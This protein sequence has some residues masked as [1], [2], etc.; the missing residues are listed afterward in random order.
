MKNNSKF[1]S[2]L[3]AASKQ[4]T[5]YI[6]VIDF[7]A[8]PI[9]TLLT[10]IQNRVSKTQGSLRWPSKQQDLQVSQFKNFSMV[11]LNLFLVY[12]INNSTL[13]TPPSTAMAYG[14]GHVTDNS[15]A[16]VNKRKVRDVI[17]IA[18][19][20]SNFNIFF[21]CTIYI[22][23]V[24]KIPQLRYSQLEQLSGCRMLPGISIE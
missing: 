9:I 4:S 16:Y 13:K 23:S 17:T 14:G 8:T 10:R 19:G 6:H 21:N 12:I 11:Q 5:A 7:Y 18:A 20:E 1:N 24:F 15:P 3:T 22:L 2:F